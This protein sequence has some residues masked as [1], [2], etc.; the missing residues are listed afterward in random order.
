MNNRPDSNCK[1]FEGRM[2]GTGKNA[3]PNKGDQHVRGDRE[4]ER[5]YSNNKSPRQTGK[6]NRA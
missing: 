4:K 5:G 6:S 2:G 3:G 1:D